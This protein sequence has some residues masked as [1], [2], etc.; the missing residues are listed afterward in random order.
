[1]QLT[2]FLIAFLY[3]K[4]PFETCYFRRKK[5]AS[6]AAILSLQTKPNLTWEAQTFW[7]T[8]LPHKC[9]LLSKMLWSQ[10]WK[11]SD[12]N[13]CFDKP[14]Q[15]TCAATQESD[16]LRYLAQQSKHSLDCL[17][18]SSVD[19]RPWKYWSLKGLLRQLINVIGGWALTTSG[20]KGIKNITKQNK[21][22]RCKEEI[23]SCFF[24]KIHILGTP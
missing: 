2:G 13:D 19:A 5:I 11:M 4:P 23:F 17:H 10:C 14:C 9:I 3:T 18:I 6:Q 8:F 15:M 7:Q 16:Q 12:G 22:Q 20:V 21:K 1:M 24:Q